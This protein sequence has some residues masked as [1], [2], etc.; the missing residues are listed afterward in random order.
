MTA[1]PATI[2]HEGR[3]ARKRSRRLALAGALLLCLPACAPLYQVKVDA[4]SVKEPA[5][6][7]TYVLSPLNPGVDPSDLQFREFAGY[8][9][10]ALSGKGLERIEDAG[11]ADLL[12]LLDYGV[13]D[14]DEQI[15]SYG[16]S[17]FWI[18]PGAYLSGGGDPPAVYAMLGYPA[19]VGS[20]TT[21]RR[22]LA[23]LAY[24]DENGTR[25]PQAWR[26]VVASRGRAEDLRAIFPA[27]L[28]AAAPY[29]GEN[30]SRQ[31]SVSIRADDEA[32]KQL[33][34][35]TITAVRAGGGAP[36]P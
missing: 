23:L 10:T 6:R 21:W 11:R 34:A 16:V 36:A 35:R 20:Y 9:A 19:P 28:A 27:M 1:E 30:T 29:I 2:R 8:V 31:V 12:V 24:V 13:G 3:E 5:A 14:P 32:V 15:Y 26:T 7:T 18:P 25:G 33:E 22:W 17:P 4:L